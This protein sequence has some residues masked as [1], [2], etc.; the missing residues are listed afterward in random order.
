MGV[1]L[2]KLMMRQYKDGVYRM[3]R[4]TVAKHVARLEEENAAFKQQIE[5]EAIIS[6]LAQDETAA[7]KREIIEIEKVSDAHADENTALKRGISDIY[8]GL[9]GE[10][11]KTTGRKLRALLTAEE[12]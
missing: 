12:S 4:A 8:Y 2:S 10:E 9:H 1:E 3:S 6:G 7:F 5:L 11:L